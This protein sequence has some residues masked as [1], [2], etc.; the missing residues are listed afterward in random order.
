MEEI[1]EYANEEENYLK[2]IVYMLEV[3]QKK[4]KQQ[5]RAEYFSKLEEEDTKGSQ[6]ISRLRGILEKVHVQLDKDTSDFLQAHNQHVKDKQKLHDELKVRDEAMQKVLQAQLDHIR[7]SMDRIRALKIRLRESQKQMG[8]RVADLDNEHAFFQNAFNLLKRKLIIDRAVDF[9]KLQT[10]TVNF[11]A[12]KQALEKLQI[13]GEH[14]LHVAAVCRKLETQEEKILPFPCANNTERVAIDYI[15]EYIADMEYF[16]QRVGQAD[17]SRYAILE[18]KEFLKTENEILKIKVHRY[19]QCLT[20]PVQEKNVAMQ[21]KVMY[22][23]EGA[24]EQKKYVKHDSDQF[25]SASENNS[26]IDEEFIF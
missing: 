15:P 14:I 20:C 11:D 4:Q 9:Q 12:T 26:S 6:M 24:L 21:T 17:A 25:G 8:R 1:N 23:T 7:K 13:R 3:A 19:C 5:V 18:E 16:W 22:I 2:T 10:L